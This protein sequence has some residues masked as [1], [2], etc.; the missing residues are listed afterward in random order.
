MRAAGC[1]PGAHQYTALLTAF[2]NASDLAG[3]LQVLREMDADGVKPTKE[4]FTEIIVLLGQ[5]GKREKGGQ[6]GV[7]IKVFF[8]ALGLTLNHSYVPS[9]CFST[10]PRHGC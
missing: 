1:P 6:G 10:L 9:L 3:G 8:E 7:E 2:R 4:T 5:H